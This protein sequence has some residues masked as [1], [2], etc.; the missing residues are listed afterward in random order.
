[1]SSTKP[2]SALPRIAAE[3][4][5]DL[6]LQEAVA[7]TLST[8]IPREVAPAYAHGPGRRQDL[9]ALMLARRINCDRGPTVESLR[10]CASCGSPR[11]WDSARPLYMV[12]LPTGRRERARAD[13]YCS[14][15]PQRPFPHRNH[16]DEF[17]MLYTVVNAL[18]RRSRRLAASLILGHLAAKSR[19][20]LSPGHVRSGPLGP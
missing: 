11:R 1:M 3:N 9:D 7:R 12:G 18:L 20:R 15:Q 14:L 13:R 5:P 4:L 6:V 16:L 8:R 19:R 2:R 17:H 10:E